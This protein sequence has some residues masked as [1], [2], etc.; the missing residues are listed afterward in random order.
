ML[1]PDYICNEENIRFDCRTPFEDYSF[2]DDIN[3][4]SLTNFYSKLLNKRNIDFNKW[5]LKKD[6]KYSAF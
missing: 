4:K 5:L 3:M 6:V 1:L 2:D